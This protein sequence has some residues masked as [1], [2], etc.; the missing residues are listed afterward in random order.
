MKRVKKELDPYIRQNIGEA[1]IQLTE[2]TKP[3]NLAGT[4]RMYYVGNWSKD[5]YDN[6]TEKQA[7]KI[8]KEIDKLKEKLTFFQVKIPSFKDE[9]GV[10][11]SGYEYYAKKV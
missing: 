1:R 8:F 3:S 10:E 6:F 2:L 9:E 11:W 4:Q 5:I 7:E